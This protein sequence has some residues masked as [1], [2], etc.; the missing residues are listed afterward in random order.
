VIGNLKRVT[1]LEQIFVTCWH[2][3]L[4]NALVWFFG[5]AYEPM[6]PT[7]MFG[8]VTVVLYAYLAGKEKG[9]V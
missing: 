1:N 9:N 3:T 8:V 4:A 5:D 6:L 7:V 2:F